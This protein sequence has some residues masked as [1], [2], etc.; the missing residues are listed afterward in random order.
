MQLWCG[1]CGCSWPV[2]LQFDLEEAKEL[3]LQVNEKKY[4]CLGILLEENVLDLHMTDLKKVRFLTV[5]PLLPKNCK[6]SCGMH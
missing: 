2:E 4:K 1:F 3:E 6:G 5:S